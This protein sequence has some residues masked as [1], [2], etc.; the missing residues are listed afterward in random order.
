MP[1]DQINS[2]RD[3]LKDSV[4]QKVDFS[5]TDQSKGI[6][7]PPIQKGYSAHQKMIHLPNKEEWDSVGNISLSDAIQNRRSRRKYTRDP[8]RL[9]ELAFL[10]W[11]TQGVRQR[12]DSG[13]AFRTV[14]SAGCRHSFETYLVSLNVT[15]LDEGI[16]RYLPVDSS[17]VLESDEDGLSRKMVAATLGQAF[18]G[19]AAAVFVWTTIP[20]RMEWRYDIAAHRVIAMDVGHVCQN[21]YLACE[22]IGSGTCAIAAFDQERMDQLVNVDGRDEFVIYL[23]PVGKT[24]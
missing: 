14:P 21:L 23:A 17:L 10:L 18:V 7:A 19:T 20:Y 5:Q 15:G 12:I 3:F 1:D 2:Y 22:A 9:D 13:H 11:S 6:A 24:P 8:M 16:Y 4:R